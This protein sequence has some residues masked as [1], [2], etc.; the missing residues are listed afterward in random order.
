MFKSFFY[1]ASSKAAAVLLILLL[2]FSA[3]SPRTPGISLEKAETQTEKNGDGESW[4]SSQKSIPEDVS[5]E[6]ITFYPY[7]AQKMSG[8]DFTETAPTQITWSGSTSAAELS[9]ATSL[10]I[11]TYMKLAEDYPCNPFVLLDKVSNDHII[12]EWY[13]LKKQSYTAYESPD[14]SVLHMLEFSS[15]HIKNTPRSINSLSADTLDPEYSVAN[16][17]K[18]LELAGFSAPVYEAEDCLYSYFGSVSM[19][20]HLLCNV[21]AVYFFPDSEQENIDHAEIQFLYHQ[22]SVA[23]DLYGGWAGSSTS[24]MMAH[25]F[26]LMKLVSIIHVLELT[27][28]GESD[29]MNQVGADAEGVPA[30]YKPGSGNS[31]MQA[32]LSWEGGPLG[33][34]FHYSL[35]HK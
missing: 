21:A 4:V 1:Q 14:K 33:S 13:N 34:V 12:Q 31:D 2:S 27:L 15:G 16:C 26:S 8:R 9:I 22:T 3:C 18:L 20:S 11:W 17:E 30:N 29:V 32:E 25:D 5:L 7:F 24:S 28:A 35:F 6:M 23:M 19:N 10:P